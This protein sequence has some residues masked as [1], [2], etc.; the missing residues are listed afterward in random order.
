MKALLQLP[1]RSKILLAA[2]IVIL[3]VIFY[4]LG[5]NQIGSKSID[6]QAVEAC[7]NHSGIPIVSGYDDH[8]V[9]CQSGPEPATRRY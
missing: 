7:L 6:D 8:M 4:T 3:C 1:G 9:A 5:T 2:G